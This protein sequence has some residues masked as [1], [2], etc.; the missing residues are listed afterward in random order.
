MIYIPQWQWWWPQYLFGHCCLVPRTSGGW[1]R[2]AFLLPIYLDQYL[3]NCQA[4]DPI[5]APVTQF[6]F[7]EPQWCQ[8]AWQDFPGTF[9]F[10]LLVD[11]TGFPSTHWLLLLFIMVPNLPTHLADPTTYYCWQTLPHLDFNQWCWPYYSPARTKHYLH[12]FTRF[13]CIP[14]WCLLFFCCGLLP[15]WLVLDLQL[16]VPVCVP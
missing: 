13:Y 3:P 12:L 9:F 4:A 16:C 2:C 10:S 7:L 5:T 15:V 14:Q 11:P 8:W 1:T 6:S